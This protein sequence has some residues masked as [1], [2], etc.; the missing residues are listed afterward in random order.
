MLFARGAAGVVSGVAAPVC[1][2][3]ASPTAW[4]YLK[5]TIAPVRSSCDI[6]APYVTDG[7]GKVGRNPTDGPPMFSMPMWPAIAIHA[8]RD[9]TN[10]VSS[11]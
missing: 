9:I 6:T 7:V 10:D 8:S 3:C 11:R 5:P 4:P 1:P 2:A